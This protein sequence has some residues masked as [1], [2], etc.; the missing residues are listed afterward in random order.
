MIGALLPAA[1]LLATFV[2]GLFARSIVDHEADLWRRIRL[3]HA[4]AQANRLGEPAYGHTIAPPGVQ[5]GPARDTVGAS[6][7]RAEAL[8]AA[9]GARVPVEFADRTGWAAGRGISGTG[10]ISTLPVEEPP[11]AKAPPGFVR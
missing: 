10:S 9:G 8:Y 1:A 2:A 6:V 3:G 5:Y 4:V 7:P 11:P